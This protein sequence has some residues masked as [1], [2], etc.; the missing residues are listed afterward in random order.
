MTDSNSDT[1]IETTDENGVAVL[2]PVGATDGAN[3]EDC[4]EE[5]VVRRYSGNIKADTAFLSGT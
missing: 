4:V 5:D 2:C 1:F 3:S